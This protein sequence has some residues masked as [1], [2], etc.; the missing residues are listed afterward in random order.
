MNV[1]KN[2]ALTLLAAVAVA[3]TGCKGDAGPTGTA[4]QNGTTTV[5]TLSTTTS[6]LVVAVKSVTVNPDQT[7]SVN[8]TVKDDQGNPVDLAGVYSTNVAMTPRFSLSKVNVAADGTMLPYTVLTKTG[9]STTSTDPST[10]TLN[11]TAIAPLNPAVPATSGAL[12]ENGSGAGDYTYIFPSGGSSTAPGTGSNTGKTV[13]TVANAVTLDPKST[14]TYVVWIE[15]A[16]QTNLTNPTAAASFKA[17]NFEYDFIP[18]GTGTPLK[19]QVAATADCTNCHRGFRPEGL[20]TNGFHNGTRVEAAYCDVCH[21]IDRHSTA[22]VSDGTT[23]AAFSAIFVHRIHASENLL[24]QTTGTSTGGYQWENACTTANPCVCTSAHPCY[25]AGLTTGQ[26][27]EEWQGVTCSTTKACT[28]TTAKPCL[29]N[30]FHAIAD[31]TYPQDL[32]NCGACHKDA[33]QGA[34]A[35]TTANRAVCGSCHDYVVFDPTK[36]AGL[37]ACVDQSGNEAKDAN[38]NWLQCAHAAGAN[39]DDTSCKGC[40]VQGGSGYIGDFHVA[41]AMPDPTNSLLV[42]G[43][44]TH[45]NQMYVAAAG[46]LPPGAIQLK[47]V[48]SQVTAVADS[49]GVLRPQ[50]TFKFQQSTDGKNFSDVAFNTFGSGKTELMDNFVGSP[51]VYF[52]FATPQDGITAPADFNATASA[53]IK[54]VWNGTAAGTTMSG[55][56]GSGFYTITLTG[57]IIPPSAKMLTGGVGYTYGTTAGSQPTTQ[58]NLPAYPYNW[59]PYSKTAVAGVGGLAVPAPNAWA[60]ATGNDGSGKA[61]VGRRAIVENARCLTCHTALGVNPTFHAGQRNDGPTCSFCHTPNKVNGGW[62]VNGKYF[63]H[64]IHAG[65]FRTMPFPVDAPDGT[66]AGVT[67]PGPLNDCEACHAPGS[68]DLSAAASAA[69]QPN[70]LATTVATGT[71]AASAS[72]SPYVTVGT[73]YGSGYATSGTRASLASGQAITGTQGATTCTAAAPC[74][75][76]VASPCLAVT[77]SVTYPCDADPTTLVISP[78]TAACVACHDSAAA[79]GHIVANGGLFYAPRSEMAAQQQ[80]IIGESCLVCH[81]A[82]NIASIA[83]VHR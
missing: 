33:A 14:D 16:R 73:N 79:N 56:D 21:N 43:G 58:I 37:P 61:W 77:C 76:T 1:L 26:S 54:N 31:V 69:A 50:I 66:W 6:G 60:V 42:A 72:T 57:S 81:G 40:H 78:I 44:N 34:Q 28:C 19:R 4:G 10:V 47:Y 7:V 22:T 17:V 67:F 46:A 70:M 9:T 3:G 30:V 64:A 24:R 74:T 45:T 75:C 5:T 53:Y 18:A 12:S 8:F 55:P 2:R 48:V 83:D 62:A 80:Q 27:T 36:V 49:G 82:G 13:L 32:R 25:P 20:T 68:Y 41:V 51:S 59:D 23:P 63:I 39:T 52:A 15:A 65:S 71:M 11:P 38:G 35:K 29:P